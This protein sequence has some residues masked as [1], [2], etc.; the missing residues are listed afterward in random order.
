MV[1]AGLKNNKDI[2]YGQIREQP[3]RPAKQQDKDQQR[4]QNLGNFPP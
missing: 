3:K 4:F 2:T 1:K